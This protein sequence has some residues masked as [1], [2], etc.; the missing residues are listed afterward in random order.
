MSF[1]SI[2]ATTLA[3]I[4]ACVIAG[5]GSFK[6]KPLPAFSAKSIGGKP[7]SNSV[8]KGKVVLLDF[9]ATWCGPCKASMPMI[10]RIHRQ[11]AAKGLVVIGASIDEPTAVSAKYVKSNGF[12]YNFITE[13]NA[14]SKKLGIEGIP[15]LLIIDKTGKVQ[16]VKESF[17]PAGE[18][19]EEAELSALIAKLLK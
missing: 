13:Q 18:K 17:S 1:R 11:F 3:C 7:L 19:K 5:P 12:T 8:L 10:E 9:W 4:A 6:G 15:V 2:F 16:F 14:L